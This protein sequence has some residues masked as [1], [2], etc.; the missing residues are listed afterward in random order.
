M[1]S[2]GGGRKSTSGPGSEKEET[3]RPTREKTGDLHPPHPLPT[4]QPF[5]PQGKK[6]NAHLF[7]APPS[8]VEMQMKAEAAL[9]NKEEAQKSR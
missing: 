7:V 9:H 4:A 8:Q 2:G 6:Q 3:P 5:L 1:G